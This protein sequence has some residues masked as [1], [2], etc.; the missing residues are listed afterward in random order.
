[1]KVTLIHAPRPEY[2]DGELR[3]QF[4]MIMPVGLLGLADRLDREGHQV[5]VLHLGLAALAD[6]AF[7]LARHLARRAPDLVGF[8]LHWHHQLA[9]VLAAAE[10]ARR[11]LP[12]AQIIMGGLTATHFA[13]ELLERFPFIHQV[14]RGDG[15]Q[16]LAAVAGGADPAGVPN[17]AYRRA[18]AVRLN[19]VT[20]CATSADL[21][22]VDF[23]RTDL[24]RDADLYSARWFLEPGHTPAQYGSGK[25]FYLC[26]G[27]GCTVDCTFCGGS[28]RAHRE[29]CGRQE[30]ALRA[31]ERLLQ[32]A[33]K[34]AAAG[35]ETLYL[36]FDPPGIPRAHYPRFFE[37]VRRAGLD[38]AMIFEC[39]RL[40]DA[41]FLDAFGRAFRA[42]GSQIALSPDA[43]DLAARRRHKG[44]SYS[45]AELISTLEACAARGLQTTLYFTLMPDDDW[46]AVRR[47]RRLQVALRRRFG[48]RVLTLPI[49]VEPA[50]AWQREPGE[51]GLEGG[52]FDLDYF[53]RR[54]RAISTPPGPAPGGPG[55]TPASL[56]QMLAFLDG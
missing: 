40:P 4:I 44:Y 22:A 34:A 15:E 12:D 53:L 2:L 23:V 36:C 10:R 48:S 27:R 47:M 33:L 19:P 45:N 56:A 13:G 24:L 1:V 41:A 7:D 29:L 26:G 14:V 39:Y 18:G 16:A 38:L 6:P 43:A 49:E 5:E 42:E 11:A 32:D 55:H 17:L 30:L 51:H 31:P 20:W 25:V 54:H 21:D 3:R 46:P 28:R 35:Y 37:L 9:A 50:A 8:S 52:P